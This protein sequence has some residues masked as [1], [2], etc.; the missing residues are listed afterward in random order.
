MIS[1]FSAYLLV[2]I[3]PCFAALYD[4]QSVNAAAATAETP[5]IR[6]AADALMQL[7]RSTAAAVAVLAQNPCVSRISTPHM[8]FRAS[9][10]ARGRNKIYVSFAVEKYG[11]E[12]RADAFAT[13]AAF[14][15]QELAAQG[16]LW[17][18]VSEFS[19]G[20]RRRLR[21]EIACDFEGPE[22]QQPEKRQRT[23][24]SASAVDLTLSESETEIVDLS[25]EMD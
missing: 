1:T 5:D 10:S 11:G 2:T 15:L 19:S 18:P 25:T 23:A 4:Y 6:E 14:K 17:G 3:S 24:A 20:D 21:D 7:R 13:Q 16:M 9:I 22:Q 12:A 8:N